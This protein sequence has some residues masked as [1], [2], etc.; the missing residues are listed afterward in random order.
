MGELNKRP[1]EHVITLRDLAEELGMDR[2]HLR[3][4]VL[5]IGIKPLRIRTKE[6]RS[7]L[8]LCVTDLD[9][10]K[11]RQARA[12]AGFS[13]G[14]GMVVVLRDKPKPK[15]PRPVVAPRVFSGDDDLFL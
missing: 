4:Y 3:R 1:N 10:V 8:T 11:I 12:A 2:S 14:K 6:S 15:R 13:P 5:G 9:A 7:Q